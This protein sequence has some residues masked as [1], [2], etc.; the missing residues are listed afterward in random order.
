MSLLTIFVSKCNNFYDWQSEALIR[1]FNR[2]KIDGEIIRLNVCNNIDSS[3][4]MFVYKSN[5]FNQNTWYT[6]NKPSI[7]KRYIEEKKP[8]NEFLLLIDSDTVFKNIIDLNYIKK[9]V[10]PGVTL[11]SSHNNLPN[12]I[13]NESHP[14]GFYIIHNKDALKLLEHWNFHYKHIE[15]EL[16]I[17]EEHK[18][19]R[20]W[21]AE[22]Y[23]YSLALKSTDIKNIV[24]NTMVLDV[25]NEP[26]Q[27]I[28]PKMLKYSSEYIVDKIHFN[29]LN[30]LYLNMSKCSGSVFENSF[31]TKE[32]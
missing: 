26:Y 3:T 22:I 30:Y 29:K 7:V 14:Y 23:S 9:I 17:D 6:E 18:F 20:N 24:D 4:N 32:T 8:K 13:T 15:K 2:L 27:Q 12:F 19:K 21:I 5:N 10:K 31:A 1:S 28:N 16:N 11:T 25:G